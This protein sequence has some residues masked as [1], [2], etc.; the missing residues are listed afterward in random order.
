MTDAT[1]GRSTSNPIGKPLSDQPRISDKKLAETLGYSGTQTATVVGASE[2]EIFTD[3][4]GR[5]Q[6][7]FPWLAE[8]ASVNSNTKTISSTVTSKAAKPLL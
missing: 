4:H 2:D 7:Q 8:D 3:K 1:T 6:V 5:V